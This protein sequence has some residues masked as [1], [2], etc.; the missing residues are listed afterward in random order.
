MK[1]LK[2]I[3]EKIWDKHL[4]KLRTDRN[5]QFA[6]PEMYDAN[7]SN[8]KKSKKKKQ[9]KKEERED[10]SNTLN[11]SSD[12]YT[13][14]EPENVYTYEMSAPPPP[15]FTFPSF[16]FPPPPQNFPFPPPPPSHFQF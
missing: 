11:Q 2:K 7:S 9:F 16:A 12:S 4:E 14:N 6:P 3:E 15:F 10:T 8:K 13:K 5:K 1:I